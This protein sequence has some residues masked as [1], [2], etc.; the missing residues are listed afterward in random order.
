MPKIPELNNST[1]YVGTPKMTD[2]VPLYDNTGKIT[3]FVSL[4][5]IKDAILGV[6]IN[7]GGTAPGDVL[8]NNGAQTISNKIISE[9]TVED[10]A[11]VQIGSTMVGIATKMTEIDAKEDKLGASD[12]AFT[13]PMQFTYGATAE[14]I[15]D[16]DILEGLGL[17]DDLYAIAVDSVLLQLREYNGGKYNVLLID[18]DTVSAVISPGA[19]EQLDQIELDG[20]TQGTVYSLSIT[21]Q[22]VE[23]VA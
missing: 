5:Q 15:S 16:K 10:T 13:Y 17:D 23:R 20:L 1:Q 8:T 9:S 22:I 11:E 3:T 12:K 19:S 6:G 2:L 4:Q 18:N 7:V 21:V 14:T